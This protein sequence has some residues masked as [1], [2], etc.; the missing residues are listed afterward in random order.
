ME[1]YCIWNWYPQ[2]LGS[3]IACP[4]NHASPVVCIIQMGFAYVP[5]S[6]LMAH[7]DQFM[8]NRH[9]PVSKSSV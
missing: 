2:P 3:F 8:I 6:D 9:Q 5:C 1:P 4:W 7:D